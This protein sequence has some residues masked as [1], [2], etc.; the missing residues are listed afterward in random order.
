[1]S[2]SSDEKEGIELTQL[3][4]PTLVPS[5]TTKERILHI[6]FR[7]FATKGYEQT[8]L[9]E[10]AQELGFTKAALYY[11]FPAKDDLLTTIVN[12]FIERIDELLGNT[13]RPNSRKARRALLEN[14]LDTILDFRALVST[15]ANDR[16]AL[17]HPQVGEKI[18]QQTRALRSLLAGPKASVSDLVR[19]SSAL[20]CIQASILH[21]DGGPGLERARTVI[22]AAALAALES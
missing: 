7:L 17:N 3:A 8:S 18:K 22:I 9:S 20:G 12:P 4:P 5:P 14:Y 19:A 21:F 11:H 1:M 2:T 6:A 16:S 10:I 13:S 15:L